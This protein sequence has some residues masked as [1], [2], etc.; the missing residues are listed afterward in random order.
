MRRGGD[1]EYWAVASK[2][3]RSRQL[4]HGPY[5]GKSPHRPLAPCAWYTSGFE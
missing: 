1:L 4:A 5:R 3:Q 2:L